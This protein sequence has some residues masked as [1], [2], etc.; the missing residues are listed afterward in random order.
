MQNDYVKELATKTFQE[1]TPKLPYRVKRKRLNPS[2]LF[3]F[4]LSMLF[5]GFY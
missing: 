4:V 5:I 3:G 1:E 2:V